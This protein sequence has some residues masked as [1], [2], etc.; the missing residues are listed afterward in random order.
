V[1]DFLGVVGD[2]LGS[3]LLGAEVVNGDGTTDVAVEG[4]LQ[5]N[6]FCCLELVQF[7]ENVDVK[8]CTVSNVAVKGK[9]E[10]RKDFVV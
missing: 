5:K 1:D 6:R 10:K 4:E 2:T 7:W 8:R 3:D 9:L